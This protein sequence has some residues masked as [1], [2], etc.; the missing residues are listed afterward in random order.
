MTPQERTAI[1]NEYIRDL[2]WQQRGDLLVALACA[3]LCTVSNLAAPVISG[4]FI[5][6]LAGRQPGS[7]YPKVR[8][9]LSASALRRLCAVQLLL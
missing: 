3:L 9:Q 4:Y 2:L 8:A 6:I 7:L 5:E 1:D